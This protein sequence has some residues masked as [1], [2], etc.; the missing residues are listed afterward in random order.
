M[1]AAVLGSAVVFLDGTIVN[2]A[3][4]VIGRELPA[5]LV[6]VLEGQTYVASGYLATLAALLVLAGALGDYYG[7][8]R[9]FL[10]GLL[11]F[12]TT[13]VLC[14]LAPNL[15]LLAI[16]R[17]LQGAAGALLVPGSLSIIMATFAGV[18]RGRAFGIWAAATSATMILGP[19]VGGILIETISWRMAFLVNIPLMLAAIWGNPGAYARESR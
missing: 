4:P 15:E 19:I 3:L 13:S 14:G 10:L 12:G 7:R 11:G 6:S 9:V 8:R 5:S 1:V 17:V 2:V 16:F 18:A